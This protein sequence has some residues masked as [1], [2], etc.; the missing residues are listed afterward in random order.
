MDK[1]I[2]CTPNQLLFKLYLWLTIILSLKEKRFTKNKEIV[3]KIKY[4]IDN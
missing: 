2:Y 3:Q 4:T 1:I